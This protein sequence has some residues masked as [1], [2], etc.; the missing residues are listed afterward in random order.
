[1]MSWDKTPFQ[2]QSPVEL[3]CANEHTCRNCE[4]KVKKCCKSKQ[5]KKKKKLLTFQIAP[6]VG[7]PGAKCR[8]GD[9]YSSGRDIASGPPDLHLYT[10]EGKE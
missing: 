5:K 8:R 9:W 1:M 6:L 2:E 10:P 4:R 3:H 7:S